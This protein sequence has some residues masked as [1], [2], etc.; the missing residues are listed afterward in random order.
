MSEREI[1]TEPGEQITMDMIKKIEKDTYLLKES[2]EIMNEL[3]R[4]Q[5][6]SLDSIENEIHYSSSQVKKGKEDLEIAEEY[7]YIHYYLYTATTVIGAGLIYL[8]F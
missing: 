8:L 2:M 3:V 5:G 6:H 4:D 1:Q 7:S